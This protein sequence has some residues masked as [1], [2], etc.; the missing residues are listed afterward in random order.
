[1]PGAPVLRCRTKAA[2]CHTPKVKDREEQLAKTE[3]AG[4]TILYVPLPGFALAPRPWLLQ[5]VATGCRRLHTGLR[6]RF[7]CCGLQVVATGCRRPFLCVSADA[8]PLLLGGRTSTEIMVPSESSGRKRKK[9]DLVHLR[10]LPSNEPDTQTGQVQWMW[11]EIEAAFA[12]GRTVKEIWEAV[13]R[14]GLSIPYPQFRVYVTRTRRMTQGRHPRRP[15]ERQQPPTAPPTEGSSSIRQPNTD[16][17]HNIRVQLE[18][19]RQSHF[20]YNPFPDPNDSVG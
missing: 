1:V 3:A 16:P 10:S 4:T 9:T 8:T 17:L 2:R 12:K 11:P 7:C 19:K 14:D 5:V 6:G 20:E 15:S 18:K 13:R